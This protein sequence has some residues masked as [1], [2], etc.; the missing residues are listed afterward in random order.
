MS[1]AP[2]VRQQNPRRWGTPGRRLLVR[3]Q[4]ALLHAW[5]FCRGVGPDEPAPLPTP[6]DPALK[7]SHPRNKDLFEYFREHSRVATTKTAAV[8]DGYPLCAHEDLVDFLY[9]LADSREVV[10]GWAYGRPVLANAQ[11]LV[12]AW[13]GG[14]HSIFVRLRPEQH[15]HARHE[16]GWFDPTYGKDWIEFRYGG[17]VGGPPDWLSALRRWVSFAY[18]ESLEL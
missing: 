17:R 16:N 3:V 9:S 2:P 7:F 18:Q 15:E 14:T 11:G 1:K 4:L 12:F 10:R 6:P 13:A 8:L 5:D